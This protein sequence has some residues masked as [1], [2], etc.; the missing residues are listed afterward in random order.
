MEDVGGAERHGWGRFAEG[1]VGVH[2][3]DR[4]RDRTAG[5]E[6]DSGRVADP[7]AGLV[8]LLFAQGD[9]AG[10]GWVAV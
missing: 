1:A 7:V 6:Q 5:A 2:T 3:G 8:G 9:F 4:G 10:G